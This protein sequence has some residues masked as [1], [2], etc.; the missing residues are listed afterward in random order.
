MPNL[1]K[2]FLIGNTTRDPEVRYTPKGAAVAEIGLAINNSYKND[3]GEVIEGVTFVDVTLFGRVAEVAGEYLKKGKPVFVEG[4]LKLDSWEDKQTGQKRTKLKVVAF[5]L[6]LLGGRDA[7]NMTPEPADPQS[8][9]PAPPARAPYT[10]PP[11]QPD[12]D[13]IPF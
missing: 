13:N 5:N 12:D 7:S 2:V 9:Q 10:P 11:S 1:N 4:N 6:Q 8:T 3:R